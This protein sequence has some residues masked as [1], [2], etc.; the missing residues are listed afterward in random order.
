MLVTPSDAPKLSH[1]ERVQPQELEWFLR[2]RNG[3][4]PFSPRSAYPDAT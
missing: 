3:S 2:A 4:A 1:H